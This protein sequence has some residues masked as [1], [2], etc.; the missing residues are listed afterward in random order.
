MNS[1][2]TV[3]S[4]I[5]KKSKKTISMELRGKANPKFLLALNGTSKD[6]DGNDTTTLWY[7]TANTDVHGK[8]LTFY[9]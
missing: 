3:V 4:N 9:W 8:T 5:L 6:S 1:L 2:I 7:L